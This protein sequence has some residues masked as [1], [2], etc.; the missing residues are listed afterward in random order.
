V[1]L[2]KSQIAAI[3]TTDKH[4][5]IIACAGSGK[6]DVVSRRI[7]RIIKLGLATPDQIVAFTFTEKAATELKERVYK[8]I[9]EDIGNTEGLAEMFIG[10]MHAYCLEILQTYVPEVFKF[11]VLPDVQTKLLVNRFSNQSG[12]TVCPTSSPGTPVLRKFIN[13]GLYIKSLSIYREDIVDE[14]LVPQGFKNSLQNYLDLLDRHSYLD[15]TDILIRAVEAMEASN[16]KHLQTLK[17]RLDSYRFITVD[18]Y[19]DINP[20]QERLV[21]AM[22]GK[23]AKLCV[24]GDDDQTIYQWRG[25][26]VEN[27]LTFSK[28]RKNVVQVVLDDNF[29]SSKGIVEVAKIVAGNIDPSVR[30]PKVMKA[31]G[32]QMYERGDI[33]ALDFQSPDL[34]A[35]WI[36]SKI[37]KMH[38]VTFADSDGEDMRGLSWSDFAVL[39]RS[40]SKDAAPLVEEFKRLEIPFIIKGLSRLFEADEIIAIQ[41]AFR[42]AAEEITDEEFNTAW[43]SGNL[44]SGKKTTNAA[45]KKLEE[46]WTLTSSTKFERL[47]LQDFFLSFLEALDIKESSY[48]NDESRG[49]VVFYL[50]G[51]FSQIISDFESINY[52]MKPAEKLR[53]FSQWLIHEAPSVY[54][55]AYGEASYARPDA[56][57]ISTVHQAK[58]MQWPAVFVPSMQ[59]N[60]F[61]SRRMGGLNVTHV[62]PPEAINNF[63]RYRGSL[64]DERRLFYVAVTR[65]QKYLFLSYAP[66]TVQDK[67]NRSIFLNEVTSS[68]FVNTI[69]SVIETPK[70]PPRAK[71]EN[72]DLTITFSELKYLF[73][74][75][76]QFKI[77][78]LYG[79]NSPIAEAMGFGRG[80]HD[81]LSEVHKEALVGNYLTEADAPALVDRHLWTPFANEQLKA[82]LRAAAISAVERYFRNHGDS[83]DKTIHS[84]KRIQVHI[85]DGIVVDGRIDLIKRLD[86]S[87]VAIVD[88]KSKETSQEESL[89]MDQLHVYAL[90]YSELTGENADVLEILNL[91][92]KGKSIRTGISQKL[93]NETLSKVKM[94]GE[95]IKM[96]KMEKHEKWCTACSSCD[97]VSLC[98]KREK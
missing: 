49:E 57:V 81:A 59:Q 28:S 16:S 72:I 12:L 60:R 96:N 31:N 20:I 80:L 87:E 18:E 2:T 50:M 32:H 6:T 55:E 41:A 86:T 93:L 35:K 70:I 17:K 65:A 78:F 22:C 62:I 40:V 24:V 47:N 56:V 89:T 67:R 5:Q 61:P 26:D 53:T 30:L 9:Q 85:G 44:T 3:E 10:T 37:Q 92:E 58:G 51:K 39:F 33:L 29:R 36:A 63:D 69:D 21:K 79:F 84:E 77:R 11:R 45:R 95:Q 73:Q 82:N 46:I 74:C 88:F 42:Y 43:E 97:F 8:Y 90:G 15:Y 91:D 83:L 75:P 25:S 34:E 1:P 52:Q 4:L 7:A 27:I 98:R 19:Q 68:S 23:S 76:Y 48:P 13:T 94:A 38:G 64:E 14:S 54:E 66:S 71:I